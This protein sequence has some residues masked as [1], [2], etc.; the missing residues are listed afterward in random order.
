MQSGSRISRYRQC[1]GSLLALLLAA[2]MTLCGCTFGATIDTL[3]VPPKMSDEQEQIY[4]ALQ[5]AVGKDI[6]LQYPKSGDYL[7]AFILADFDG[8][9]ED[10]SLVFY[11]K[12]GLSAAENSL[13]VNVLDKNDG[14]W[15][16]VCDIPAE[17]AEIERVMI[18]TLG[19]QT[20]TRIIIGYSVMDQSDRAL[21]VYDYA[22]GILS[23]GFS[24][25]YS[26]FDIHDLDGDGT[27]ELLILRS[28]SSATGA[29]AAVYAP[30]ENEQ[31][32]KTQLTLRSGCTG[33]SQVL[34]AQQE[35][36]S[37]VVYADMLTGVTT[38][39]TE[40]FR[41]D[42]LKMEHVLEDESAA[43]E[44]T[45]PVG[46][47]TLDIDS[48]GIP[49]IPVQ[50]VFP[51]YEGTASDQNIRLTRWMTAD[52][53]QLR[54][55]YRGY[56]SVSEG[57]AFMLPETW[58]EQVTAISDG[59]TGDI[60]FYHYAGSLTEPMQELLRIGTASDRETRDSRLAEG[61]RLLHSRGNAYYFM[62]TVESTDVLYLP[63]SD[64][65]GCFLFV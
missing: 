5:N 36:G 31:F 34:Y 19:V 25:S 20:D 18:S 21:V 52:G 27:Q 7:S 55:K 39:Q 51:G 57:Y 14:T 46:C 50:T 9:R 53:G 22:D 23:H 10:E 29:Q 45:R 47:L 6:K 24:A 65:L 16:S 2:V 60:V 43:S 28:D 8:D 58:R 13:R 35:D 32:R 15:M 64:L 62:E 38:M 40:L 1:R 44:T 30:D 3:L 42:G 17:G 56:Y 41:Y 26:L 59:L 54:E 48:D 49:E 12:T 33:F 61:Y 63:E 11:Q 37:A 4:Q